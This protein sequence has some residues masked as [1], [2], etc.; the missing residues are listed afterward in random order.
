MLFVQ[1]FAQKAKK[2]NTRDGSKNVEVIIFEEPKPHQEIE[3]NPLVKTDTVVKQAAKEVAREALAND[4]KNGEVEID[5]PTIVRKNRYKVAIILPFN[6]GATYGRM[7]AAITDYKDGKDNIKLPDEDILRI[8]NFYKGILFA[9][10]LLPENEQIFD[11]YA[12][13]DKMNLAET[14]ALLEKPEMKTMDVIIGPLY[15]QTSMLVAD[16]AKKNKIYHFLPYS[17]ST[18]ITSSNPYHFKLTPSLDGVFRALIEKEYSFHKNLNIVEI[19]SVDSTK[20]FKSPIKDYVS[21]FNDSL[22]A[23]DSV[24]YVL[25]YPGKYG[26]VSSLS[27][28]I[29]RD[30]HNIILNSYSNV[31]QLNSF[32]KGM[33]GYGDN[34]D[35][36]TLS[37]VLDLEALRID[38]MNHA[39]PVMGEIV[40]ENPED[41]NQKRLINLFDDYYDC[42]PNADVWFGF[43]TLNLIA[44]L[45]NDYG[46]SIYENYSAINYQGVFADFSF[47][48]V[49]YDEKDQSLNFDLFENQKMN[50]YKVKDFQVTPYLIEGK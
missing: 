1:A 8:V 38:Y 26:N 22:K 36:F 24:S 23:N 4:D 21:L 2:R 32:F 16:F 46:L 31:G 20:L 25:L 40:M 37:K 17:P 27:S 14:K 7:A 45:L 10:K 29:K 9:T 50:F 42:T 49:K 33:G 30:R 39:E 34:V 13:D 19:R 6:Y 48:P 47:A 11:I 5:T 44:S 43:E 12:F 41:E 3:N 28:Y 15:N 35:V 18:T